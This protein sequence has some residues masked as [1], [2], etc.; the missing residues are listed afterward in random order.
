M[1]GLGVGLALGGG[2]AR[3]LAHIGVLR[4]LMGAGIPISHLAGSSFGSVVAA[5]YACGT[6][7][8]LEGLLCTLTYRDLVRFADV[9]FSGGVLR[10]DVLLA[11]LRTLTRDLDFEGLSVPLAVVA[12][13]LNTGT[14]KILRSGSVAEAVRASMSVPGL[15]APVNMGDD[16]LG[17]G[18]LIEMLPVPTLRE[19]GAGLV[20]GVDV[21]STSDIWTRAATRARRSVGKMRQVVRR[22]NGPVTKPRPEPD[23]QGWGFFHTVLTAFDITETRLRQKCH[24]DQASILIRPKVGHVQGHQF[25]RAAEIISAGREAIEPVIPSLLSALEREYPVHRLRGTA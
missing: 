7:S 13:D 8:E 4:G 2:A 15:F 3:G 9:A 14:R 25:Y 21:S 17:D 23:N 18:G 16:V 20:V 6:L 22:F 10:G 12:T 24:Q 5:S 1:K 11:E 19:L